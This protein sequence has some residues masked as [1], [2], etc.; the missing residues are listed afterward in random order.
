VKC[1]ICGKKVDAEQ[2]EK[3]FP[4]W[5]KL[6]K[7]WTINAGIVGEANIL[8]G[9]RACLQNVDSKIVIPERITFVCLMREIKK[10]MKQ[11][12]GKL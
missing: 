3:D 6:M 7:Y 2:E 9:H 5:W 11:E 4:Y 12:Q 10:Q 1:D 8:K